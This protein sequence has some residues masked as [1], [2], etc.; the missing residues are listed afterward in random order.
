M[1]LS[2]CAA[3]IFV[4]DELLPLERIKIPPLAHGWFPTRPSN[5]TCNKQTPLGAGTK[6]SL[7][8]DNRASDPWLI[9]WVPR[10]MIWDISKD[11]RR[12]EE[13]K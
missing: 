2:V 12:Q 10:E 4:P 3:N 6:Y 8:A 7:V 13:L 1:G 11:Y 9:W 5:G